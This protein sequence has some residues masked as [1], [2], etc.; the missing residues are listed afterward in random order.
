MAKRAQFFGAPVFILGLETF[1]FGTMNKRSG[2]P[3]V[4]LI[5][6]M[7]LNLNKQSYKNIYPSVNYYLLI[8]I[9][10]TIFVSI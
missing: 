10:V 2:A 9:I 7:R 4:H 8:N 1:D 5:L 6:L 3:G